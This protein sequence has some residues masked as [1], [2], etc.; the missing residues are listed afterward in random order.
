MYST[1]ADGKKFGTKYILST[2][3]Y[4]WMKTLMWTFYFQWQQKEQQKTKCLCTCFAFQQHTLYIFLFIRSVLSVIV[5]AR[6]FDMKTNVYLYTIYIDLCPTPSKYQFIA[7][8]LNRIAVIVSKVQRNQV[9]TRTKN[10]SVHNGFFSLL[11]L[12]ME[13]W[14]ATRLFYFILFFVYRW[15]STFDFIWNMRNKKGVQKYIYI[16]MRYS[17]KV[18][19][20]QVMF[21]IKRWQ[22]LPNVQWVKHALLCYNIYKELHA[23]SKWI[24]V[25]PS[26]KKKPLCKHTRQSVLR[27]VGGG[28]EP[29]NKNGRI[30]VQC[31][32]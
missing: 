25:F 16:R 9:K 19:H 15:N 4:I 7:S 5:C 28:C 2:Y 1:V 17:V 11:I 18:F 3:L 14:W 30:I 13:C 32:A 6:Y 21:H 31:V 27:K 8:I 12:R 22:W 24:V 29:Q 26:L 23:L 20:A 10:E